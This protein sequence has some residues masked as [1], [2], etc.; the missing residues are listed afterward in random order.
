MDSHAAT[1]SPLT[2]LKSGAATQPIFMSHGLRGN[3]S[4]LIPVASHISTSRAIFGVS[5]PGADGT[6]GSF[7]SIEG[8]AAHYLDIIRSQQPH[9][10]YYLIGYSL[11]GLAFFEMCRRLWDAGDKVPM[12]V[13]LE[14]YPHARSLSLRERMGQG[15]ACVKQR[16]AGQ[17]RSTDALQISVRDQADS[18]TREWP[19]ELLEKAKE[20]WR[21]YRPAAYP[22]KVYF[23]KSAI[24]SG[25]AGDPQAIWSKLAAECHV[26][27]V[28][29]NHTSMVSQH[30]RELA[31]E[32]SR[33]L[34]EA[35]QSE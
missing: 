33:C 19:P 25:F 23:V 5:A 22:G 35:I 20:A 16:L 13:M 7:D 21:R 4:D 34:E 17:K 31:A 18:A 10:P 12:L 9:G 8:L 3:I 24:K 28:A 27:T 11:G 14:A 2:L 15:L 29:G 26:V 1:P 30:F 32:L 6:A